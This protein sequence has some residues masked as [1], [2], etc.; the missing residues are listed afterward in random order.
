MLFKRHLIIYI[1]AILI[2][3]LCVFVTNRYNQQKRAAYTVAVVSLLIFSCLKFLGFFYGIS[4]L[5]AESFMESY[6]ILLCLVM[7]IPI[8]WGGYDYTRYYIHKQ[9]LS[10]KKSFLLQVSAILLL[11]LGGYIHLFCWP[12]IYYYVLS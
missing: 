6:C 11:A 5:Y 12:N 3:L 2:Y 9:K 10:E 4:W 7:Y 1:V 8:V